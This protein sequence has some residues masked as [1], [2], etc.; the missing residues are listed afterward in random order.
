[1]KVEIIDI[2]DRSGSMAHLRQDV[3]GGFNAFLVDQKSV[4]GEARLTHIQFDNHYE[5]QYAGKD[6]QTVE[7][8]TAESYQPRGGT[9]LFDA[10]GRTL[11]EQGHRIK[12]ENWADKVIVCIR[13]DGEENSSVEYTQDKIK[14]MIEHAQEHGWEF[15]FSAANQDAFKAGASYGI[16]SVNTT[17]FAATSAGLSGSYSS[18]SA[19]VRSMRAAPNQDTQAATGGYAKTS[20]QPKI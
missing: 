10:I 17:N 8:L 1:M 18:T 5:K 7:P 20:E 19:T 16:N 4:P 6:I 2:T 12:T 9:A 11:Q 14:T 3:I 15:I 13:T